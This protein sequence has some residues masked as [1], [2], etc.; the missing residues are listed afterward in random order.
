LLEDVIDHPILKRLPGLLG[1]LGVEGGDM[2]MAEI[3]QSEGLRFDVEGTAA[4][5]DLVVAVVDA[6]IP[7]VPHPAQEHGLLKVF[8]GRRFCRV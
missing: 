2:V 1:M 4:G 7:H 3:P 5:D 8:I 6:V